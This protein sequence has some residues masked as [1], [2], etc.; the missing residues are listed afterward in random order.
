MSMNDGKINLNETLNQDNLSNVIKGLA[1]HIALEFIADLNDEILG[2]NEWNYTIK[3]SKDNHFSL[4]ISLKDW[5]IN[6]IK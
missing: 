3:D 6:H 1:Y 5:D 2:Q 4:R